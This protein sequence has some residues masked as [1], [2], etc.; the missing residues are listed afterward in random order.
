MLLKK[1][2][3][4]V[5]DEVDISFLKNCI[6]YV[7]IVHYHALPHIISYHSP[8]QSSL[9]S[10]QHSSP[11]LLS[12]AEPVKTH[13]EG[14]IVRLYIG[15]LRGSSVYW[16]GMICVHDVEPSPLDLGR[17]VLGRILQTVVK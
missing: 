14:H 2:F 5:K 13:G 3:R 8:K 12:C 9:M 1:H 4:D 7:I 11:F 15:P 17:T 16:P 10:Q 6:F